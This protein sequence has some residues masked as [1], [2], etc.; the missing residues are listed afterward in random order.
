[1]LSIGLTKVKLE[2]QQLGVLLAD[3][4][5]AIEELARDLGN[6]KEERDGLRGD[7]T[8][9]HAQSLVDRVMYSEIIRQLRGTITDR[10]R[11]LA[12]ADA[13]N[14]ALVETVEIAQ[15]F[16]DQ[17]ILRHGGEAGALV[18]RVVKTLSRWGG[19]EKMQ[20]WEPCGGGT[21]ALQISMN[22]PVLVQLENETD[23]LEIAGKELRE[24]RIP[25]TIRRY[26]PDGSYEYWGVDELIIEDPDRRRGL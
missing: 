18:T 24:K 13:R 16:V 23:P 22:A 12:E 1:M 10:D 3:A 4:N 11:S 2:R 20:T 17:S 25:F 19:D 7:L 5:N 8:S 9:L 26:L 6:T 15:A 14:A 21:R